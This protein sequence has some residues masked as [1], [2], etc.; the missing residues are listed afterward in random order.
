MLSIRIFI[1]AICVFLLSCHGQNAFASD[2]GLFKLELPDA[3]AV[4]MG[5][6]FTADADR[7]SA[8]YYNPAGIVQMD[9]IEVSAGLNWVQPQ[10]RFES[11]TAGNGN[12]SKMKEDNYLFPDVFVTTPIIKDKFYIGVG[13]SSNYG[14]GNDWEANG[15][16]AFD[17][18][19]DS[20]VNK[21]YMI[22]G[23][24]KINDQWSVGAGAIDDQSN[25]EH[26]QALAQA[27]GVSGDALFKADDNAWGFTVASLFKLNDKTSSA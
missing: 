16:S 9:S 3:A 4:G 7:P 22:T 23:A 27:N 19:K 21:D 1:A 14:A 12:T 20:F 11:L 2:S 15:F 10:V 26:D 8:V 17:T 25:F 24:Y 5:G 13:E 6:A 18:V